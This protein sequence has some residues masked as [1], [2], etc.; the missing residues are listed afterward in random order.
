MKTQEEKRYGRR[1]QKAERHGAFCA[2]CSHRV[3]YGRAL[4]WIDPMHP[5]RP[6][7]FAL[8][9]YECSVS[10]TPQR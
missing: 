8:L 5:E 9:C 2:L 4:H 6:D 3:S 7:M 1:A 10:D